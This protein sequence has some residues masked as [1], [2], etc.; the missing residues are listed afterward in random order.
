VYTGHVGVALG[1]H[2]I[3]KSI[4]LWLLILASQLPDW[5]DAGL[6]LASVRTPVPGAYSHSLPAIG[7]LAV[8][9]AIGYCM[10]LRD[11]AG[12]LIVALVVASHAAGDYLTGMKPVMPGGP[13]IGLQLYAR[14]WIDFVLESTAVVLGWLIYRNSIS[15]E[16]RNS[17][18]VF[19]LLFVLLVIQFGADIIL[20]MTKGLKKC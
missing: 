19:T 8:A 10:I 7:I 17:E 6:C 5:A 20:T 9:A 3:R 4:P 16:K 18:P 15:R 12:M 14:P 13:L 11:P 1:A 2:G